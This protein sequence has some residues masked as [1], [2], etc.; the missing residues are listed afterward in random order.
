M[1][2]ELGAARIAT[3]GEVRAQFPEAMTGG[4]YL[5]RYFTR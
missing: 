3:A 5:G 4:L 2:D 1:A